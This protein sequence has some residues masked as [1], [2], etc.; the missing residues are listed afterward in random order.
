LESRDLEKGKGRECKTFVDERILH[1]G[2]EKI[3]SCMLVSNDSL[4][5]WLT[6]TELAMG[7]GVDF[8]SCAFKFAFS[9]FSLSTSDREREVG[10]C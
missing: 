1:L 10:I 5:L 3:S 2:G 4:V 6:T 7:V 8:L 9:F